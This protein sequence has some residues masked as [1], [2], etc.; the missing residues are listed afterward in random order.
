MGIF[1]LHP[2]GC[3]I[4]KEETSTDVA[5]EDTPR[6]LVKSSVTGVVVVV[7]GGFLAWWVV[8]VVASVWD[9]RR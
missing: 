4:F 1:L 8:T 5:T 2:K 6:V 3:E 9:V 7:T